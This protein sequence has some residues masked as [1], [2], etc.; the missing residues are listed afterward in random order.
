MEY[1]NRHLPLTSI[2]DRIETER[3]H[4]M[5]CYRLADFHQRREHH[6]TAETY[7]M[8]AERA[9]QRV[10]LA[11]LNFRYQTGRSAIVRH[12]AENRYREV[13]RSR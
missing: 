6:D 12:A 9:I 1:F 10:L 11:M 5:R 3:R 7:R 4:A 13:R 2:G 8:Q